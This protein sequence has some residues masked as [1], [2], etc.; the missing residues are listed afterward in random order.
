MSDGV[1][2]WLYGV[3]VSPVEALRAVAEKKP[4]GWAFAVVVGAVTLLSCGMLS[5]ANLDAL[6]GVTFEDLLGSVLIG[7]IVASTVG[8]FIGVGILH[9]AALLFGGEGTFAGLVAAMGFAQFPAL[10]LLPLMVL[11][12]V[13]GP[14]VAGLSTVASA[15]IVV[16][17]AAL[18]VISLRE[19]HGMS[20]RAAIGTCVFS[21]VI[22]LAALVGLILLIIVTAGVIGAGSSAA[23]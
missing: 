13:G 17:V 19:A 2:D 21:A 6:P 15:G 8:Y 12:R 3:M 16:W 5:Q 20:T 22:P 7:A 9:L 10:I 11:A 4:V 14:V 1:L 23:F 18:S